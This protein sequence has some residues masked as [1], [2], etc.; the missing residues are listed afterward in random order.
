MRPLRSIVR[1]PAGVA[2]PGEAGSHAW[3]ED[4]EGSRSRHHPPPGG[5]AHPA[6]GAG[7]G[8][9]AGRPAGGGTRC[10]RPRRGRHGPRSARGQ[11]RLDLGAEAGA[12]H[13]DDDHVEALVH[14]RRRDHRR[15]VLPADRHPRRAGPAVPGHRRLHLH[16]QRARQRHPH[17]LDARPAVADLPTGQHG[18]LRAVADHQDL[19]D[20]PRPRDPVDADPLP[21]AQRGA[22]AVVRGVQPLA[23]RQR[24]G[25]HGGQQRRPSCSDPTG[26]SPPRSP[27][28][29]GS[30]PPPTATA[31]RPRTRGP[32]LPPTTR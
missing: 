24:D 19:R 12:G 23:E 9:R 11:L 16:R 28:A 7:G 17:D 10:R 20:R 8:Y 32:T 27:P 22:A 2:G 25:R 18:H 26:R 6:A 5:A 15:G 21:G 13:L 1:C 29:P 3:V 14:P 4:T 31:A 30:P